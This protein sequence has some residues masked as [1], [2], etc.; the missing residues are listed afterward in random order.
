MFFMI[1]LQELNCIRAAAEC[2]RLNA[3]RNEAMYV[4]GVSAEDGR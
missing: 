4:A 3:D 2:I 1:K